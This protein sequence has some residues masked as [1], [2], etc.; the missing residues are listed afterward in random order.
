MTH[1]RAAGARVVN[2]GAIMG[3]D[4][5]KARQLSL[6]AS[7]GWR[8]PHARGASPGRSRRWRRRL[9]YP[10]MVKANVGGSGAG[11]VRYDSLRQLAELAA[12]GLTPV[13][14]DGVW[15]VQEY[16]PAR[17]GR[18]IRC[19][20]LA[21]RFLYAI[22]LDGGGSTFDLCPADVCMADKPTITLERLARPT[23]IVAAE[24]IAAAPELDVG[25]IE[26]MIDDRDGGPQFYDLNGS[27]TSS[28][29]RSRCWAGIR[30]SGWSTGF[31]TLI[32]E[33]R[34]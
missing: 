7:W 11:I 1:W 27:P 22:A 21:G 29:T 12:D 32:K 25:G 6:M 24:R 8:R 30:T 20:V 9:G 34:A 33:V 5:S 10:V 15:L 17:G 13:G 26:Y 16:V 3:I 14:V 18:V 23:L 31:E 28:P 2:G 19:E 4:A